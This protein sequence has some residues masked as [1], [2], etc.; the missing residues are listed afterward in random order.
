MNEDEKKAVIE[1]WE[2]YC[3][4]NTTILQLAMVTFF[5]VPLDN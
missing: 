4:F 2:R 5:V 1:Y 3:K